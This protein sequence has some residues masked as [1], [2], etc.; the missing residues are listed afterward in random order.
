MHN[1]KRCST[2]ARFWSSIFG[3]AEVVRAGT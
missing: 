1:T 3:G 2:W